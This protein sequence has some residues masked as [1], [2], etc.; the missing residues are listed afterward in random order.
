M[1]ENFK[2]RYSE[3]NWSFIRHGAEILAVV[4]G[5]G[6]IA[7]FSHTHG[8]QIL[9][10]DTLLYLDTGL[11]GLE[12][13]FVLNRYTHILIIRFFSFIGTSPIEGFRAFSGFLAF[14]STVLVYYSARSFSKDSSP[15]NGVIAV[16]FLLSIPAILDRI[17]APIVDTTVMIMMLTMVAIYIKSA[18]NDHEKPWLLVLFG[19][20]FFMALRTKEVTIVA[21]I[22]IMGFGFVSDKPFS[23]SLIMKNLRYVIGGMAVAA[24]IYMVINWIVLGSPLFGF[25]FADI[26]SYR[27]QWS[28]T[29]GSA[30]KGGATF[31]GLLLTST[32]FIFVLYVSAGLL[33]R[34][35]IPWNLRLIWIIPLALITML[36]LFSTRKM[37]VIVPRGFTAGIVL[38]CVLGSQVIRIDSLKKSRRTSIVVATLATL[39]GVGLLVYFGIATNGSLP[40]EVYFNAVFVPIAFSIIVSILFLA[41]EG[42]FSELAIIFLL[43]TTSLYQIRLNILDISTNSEVSRQNARFQPLLAFEKEISKVDDLNMYVSKTIL[44]SL[45]IKENLDEISMLVNVALDLRTDRTDYELGFPD[46]GLIRGL[47]GGEY[48]LVLITSSEWDWLRAAPQDRPEW[49]NKY[50]AE[51][52]PNNRYIL[53]QRVDKSPSQNE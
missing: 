46:E 16:G 40:Y 37:W 27:D 20:I 4:L 23:L 25:R 52:E 31:T 12:N 24:L 44:P 1:I 39:F 51:T 2:I 15:V 50:F 47:E 14:I 18:R 42:P 48:S 35:R 49:R 33:A 7:S 3:V 30:D 9:G 26:I 43:L 29:I 36:I 28:R 21:A 41:R 32:G 53:L 11:R 38:I 13:T 6:M 5:A 45:V 8:G 10:T 22:L 19:A 34:K 17:I